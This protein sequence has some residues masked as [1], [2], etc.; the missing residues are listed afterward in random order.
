MGSGP[1]LVDE[2]EF[3]WVQGFSWKWLFTSAVSTYGVQ[4]VRVFT[5]F[6]RKP[7]ILAHAGIHAGTH[8]RPAKPEHGVGL[9]DGLQCSGGSRVLVG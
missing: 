7:S 3:G 6:V 1:V 5:W 8:R 9:N 2:S 4:L